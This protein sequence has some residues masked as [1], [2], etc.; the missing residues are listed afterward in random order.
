MNYEDWTKLTDT[1]QRELLREELMALGQD[2]AAVKRLVQYGVGAAGGIG[3]IL[4]S[5]ATQL[6]GHIAR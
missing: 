1:Q 5:L 4:G 2:L 3:A 6:L